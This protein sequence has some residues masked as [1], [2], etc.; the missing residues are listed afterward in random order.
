MTPLLPCRPRRPRRR[1]LWIRIDPRPVLLDVLK[2]C[3]EG[4]A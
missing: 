2:R 4:M 1:V 3:C